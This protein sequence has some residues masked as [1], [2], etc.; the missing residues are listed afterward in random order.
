VELPPPASRQPKGRRFD[1]CL[2]SQIHPLRVFSA[3]RLTAGQPGPAEMANTRAIASLWAWAS[4]VA[5]A[6]NGGPAAEEVNFL[7]LSWEDRNF[8]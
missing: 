8:G 1:S 3:C 7:T 6:L 2:R 5:R 4:A